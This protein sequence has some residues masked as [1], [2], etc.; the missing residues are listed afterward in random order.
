[1]LSNVS[2]K[3]EVTMT[4]IPTRRIREYEAMR[5]QCEATANP[6]IVTWK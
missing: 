6:N 1:M 4:V 3:P 5:F 2:V